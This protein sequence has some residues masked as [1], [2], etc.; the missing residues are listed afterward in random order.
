MYTKLLFF[1]RQAELRRGEY[2]ATNSAG[3]KEVVQMEQYALRW[4]PTTG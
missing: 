3:Q 4:Y 1:F 2:E